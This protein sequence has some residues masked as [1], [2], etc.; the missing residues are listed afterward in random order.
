M[1][2]LDVRYLDRKGNPLNGI[3]AK[4]AMARP[5]HCVTDISTD[6]Y[7]FS[8]KKQRPF[9]MSVIRSGEAFVL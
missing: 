7:F 8:G 2:G 6:C 5:T 3:G 1:P 4:E 9:C